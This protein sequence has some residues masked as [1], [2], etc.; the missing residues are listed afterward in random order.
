MQ[1]DEL[2]QKISDSETFQQFCK[3]I[4]EIHQ[5]E[6]ENQFDNDQSDSSDLFS[7]SFSQSIS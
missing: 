7:R 5:Y 3:N 1:F 6:Y 2:V 4:N